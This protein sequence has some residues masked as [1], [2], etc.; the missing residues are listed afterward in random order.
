MLA[1]LTQP[2]N[3]NFFSAEGNCHSVFIIASGPSGPFGA[4]GPFGPLCD[5]AP[6]LSDDTA[7]YQIPVDFGDTVNIIENPD[8]YVATINAYLQRV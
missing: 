6:F 2:T 8:I 5:A 1:V 4:F 7:H 3:P